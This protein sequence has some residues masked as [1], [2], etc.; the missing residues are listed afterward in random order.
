MEATSPY[1]IPD[2][3]AG[4]S[5]RVV[6]RAFDNAGNARDSVVDVRNLNLALSL[7]KDN[8]IGLSTA[9]VVIIFLIWHLRSHH[10]RRRSVV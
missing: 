3:A 4:V 9:A 5:L 6:V 10:K 2:I 8:L 7:A 1:R